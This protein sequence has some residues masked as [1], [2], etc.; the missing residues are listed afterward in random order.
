MM[1]VM[2]TA[3]SYPWGFCCNPLAITQTSTGDPSTPTTQVSS[4]VHNSKVATLLT[5][6]WV[7]A[8]PCCALLAANTGT[9][10]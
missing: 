8:S 7:A 3:A 4:S 9:K 6:T 10:A 1:R 2:T 5:S